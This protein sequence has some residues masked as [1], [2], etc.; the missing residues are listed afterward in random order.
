MNKP[1]VYLDTDFA[2]SCLMH[3]LCSAGF[4]EKA[5][6][7]RGLTVSSPDSARHAHRVVAGL[8]K[9]TVT[10]RAMYGALEMLNFAVLPQQRTAPVQVPIDLC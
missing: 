10:A 2:I 7:L 9:T 5:E 4:S 6:Q 1:L 8:P 3:T